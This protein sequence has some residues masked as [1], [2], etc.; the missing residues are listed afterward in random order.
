MF[1]ATPLLLVEQ[2][3]KP[4]STTE[5]YK[6]SEANEYDR[7]IQVK[8]SNQVIES[9]LLEK[10]QVIIKTKNHLVLI[11]YGVLLSQFESPL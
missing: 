2:H 1:T 11:Q 5:Q 8:E 4:M 9:A 10:D 7:T 3:Q 6:L